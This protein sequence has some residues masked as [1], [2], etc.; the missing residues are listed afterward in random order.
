M[1]RLLLALTASSLAL[2]CSP[3]V[4]SVPATQIVIRIEADS[5]MRA[6][7]HSLRVRT[8]APEA[9][10]WVERNDKSFAGGSLLWPVE[11]V[12]FPRSEALAAR[13]FEV[14]ADAL[15]AEG[16][17]LAQARVLTGFVL[18]EQRVVQLTLS[19]CGARPLGFVCEQDPE[20]LGPKCS[21]CV[22]ASCAQT[23]FSDPAGLPV[24]APDS[25]L[26]PG[27][28]HTDMEGGPDAN[29]ELD[30]DRQDGGI[31]DVH[32]QDGDRPDGSDT[33]GPTSCEQGSE[34]T[35]AGACLDVDECARGLDDCD[36]VPSACVN[37]ENG[38]GFSCACP[39]GYRGEGRGPDGCADIDECM[40]QTDS[41]DA[42]APCKNSL[43]SY[44]CGDCPAGYTAG[45]GGV[46]QD[47]DECASNNGG[48]DTTPIADCLN[49][50]GA[51]NTCKCPTGYAGNGVGSG[52]CVDPCTPNPC[53]TGLTCTRTPSATASCAASCASSA[54]GC[55]PGDACATDAECRTGGDSSATCD[56]TAKVC[57]R[58]CP[59]TTIVSQASLDAARYCKE[60][61]GELRIEPNFT[62]I[63]ATGFPYLTR[64]R[65]PIIAVGGITGI[66][67]IQSITIPNLQTVD[68][69]ISFSALVQMT[70]LSLPRLAT[71]GSVG[72]ANNGS[73]THL[74]LPQLRSVTR[75]FMLYQNRSLERVDIGRLTAV[76]ELRLQALCRLPWT[77]VQPISA[78][79]A[80]QTIASIG[81]CNMSTDRFACGSECSCN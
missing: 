41:C 60:V 50:V 78:L 69:D 33:L 24:F 45:A 34:R 31:P 21:T 10:S 65:G 17:V 48:C 44:S 8:A 70:L 81:C 79:G 23:P 37:L 74:S 35:D 64:V 42:L 77:Q 16:A 9:E 36:D 30:A 2:A 73:L 53:G 38:L 4:T 58:I 68:G 6:S 57:V 49:Q 46:C 76:G 19:A 66:L 13:Q 22:E 40:E 67:P 28:T 12:V 14:I 15:D 26:V 43:G 20:C 59:S 5:S 11:I 52:G 71:A 7:M 80:T 18:R 55:Q 61:N 72:V 39:T 3:E 25:Q 51:P 32:E 75:T 1:R 56:A 54:I 63:D 47:L 62:T 29:D 27:Q